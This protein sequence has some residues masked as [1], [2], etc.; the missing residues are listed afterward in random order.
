V[1]IVDATAAELVDDACKVKF[2]AAGAQTIP[3]MSEVRPGGQPVRL[4]LEGWQYGRPE[5]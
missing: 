4:Q 5:T 2:S 3:D 1:R